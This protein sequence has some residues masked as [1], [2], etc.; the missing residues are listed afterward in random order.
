MSTDP[1]VNEIQKS[2]KKLPVVPSRVK[3]ENTSIRKKK[4]IRKSPIKRLRTIKKDTLISEKKNKET[5][6]KQFKQVPAFLLNKLK[7]P[8]IQ[9][10]T[11][12]EKKQQTTTLDKN[13]VLSIV[14]KILTKFA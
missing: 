10:D 2:K 13:Q 12:A 14:D 3:K 6:E 1:K 5:K 9:K 7:T 4:E 11:L 8:D